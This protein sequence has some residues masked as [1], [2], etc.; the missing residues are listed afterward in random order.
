MKTWTELASLEET[1]VRV[2]AVLDIP[3]S[4]L[5]DRVNLAKTQNAL[6]KDNN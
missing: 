5:K 4:T 1:F 3:Y 2:A 6:R